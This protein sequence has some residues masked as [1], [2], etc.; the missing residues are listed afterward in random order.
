MLNNNFHFRMIKARVAETIVKELFQLCNF[1]VF[2]YGMERSMPTIT[3]KLNYDNSDTA[4]QIRKMPDFV[5]QSP[6]PESNLFYV[7]VKYR[8]SCEFPTPADNIKNY[9]YKNTWF[10]IVSKKD[11]RCISYSE[12]IDG[13]KPADN[14]SFLLENSNIFKLDKK[15]VTQFQNYA[16]SFFKGVE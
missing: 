14:N 13:K 16:V 2:E 4:L 8:K 10:I 5:V 3:G 6:P 1:N 9:P 12:L 7:E 15:I 11:I